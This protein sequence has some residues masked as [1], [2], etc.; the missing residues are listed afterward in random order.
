MDDALP[1]LRIAHAVGNWLSAAWWDLISFGQGLV[2]HPPTPRAVILALI[3][4]VV[5]LAIRS[6]LVGGVLYL[7]GIR[8]KP[9]DFKVK[10]GWQSK[11]ALA[12]VTSTTL[13]DVGLSD[14]SRALIV[15]ESNNRRAI[16][17]IE[18]RSRYANSF[19]DGSMEL[20]VSALEKLGMSQDDD[21]KVAKF[22]VTKQPWYTLRGILDRTILDPDQNRSLTYR[23]FV[24]SLLASVMVSEVYYERGEASQPPVS[25]AEVR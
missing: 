23:I 4:V 2:S 11:V 20:S 7:L 14:G 19:D 25:K 3:I 12:R 5:A 21:G 8:V 16:V 15:N 1:A 17:R 18:T 13:T 9:R 22:K 10:V 6:G 24:L